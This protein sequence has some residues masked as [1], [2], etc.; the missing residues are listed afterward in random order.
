VIKKRNESYNKTS[1]IQIDNNII[2]FSVINSF[3]SNIKNNI[4]ESENKFNFQSFK[5][6]DYQDFLNNG[7]KI[8]KHF[9]DNFKPKKNKLGLTIGILGNLSVGKTFLLNK[10]FDINLPLIPTTSVNYYFLNDSLRVIDSPGLNNIMG[11]TKQNKKEKLINQKFQDFVIE[12][13]V[14]D[15]SFITIFVI[16]SYNYNERKK[17]EKIKKILNENYK[18]KS[19]IKS[20]LIIHNIFQI[21][22]SKD[23]NEYIKNNF[24]IE[25]FSNKD[26]IIFGEKMDENIEKFEVLHFVLKPYQYKSNIIRTIKSQIMNNINSDLLDFNKMIE[27]TFGE[28]G[29]IVNG[30][31]NTLQSIIKN[32]FKLFDSENSSI[33]NNTLNLSE[34]DIKSLTNHDLKLWWNNFKYIT[35][36]YSCYIDSNNE[37]VIE[38]ELVGYQKCKLSYISLTDFYK[39]HI[40]AEKKKTDKSK[41][42]MIQNTRSNEDI[43]YEFK[44]P[45]DSFSFCDHKPYSINYEK[46]LITFKYKPLLMGSVFIDFKKIQNN[47]ENNDEISQNLD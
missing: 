20:L 38:I 33:N 6:K 36:Y 17:I 13:F 40:F 7:F 39:F 12:K 24:P 29:K 26:D 1:N 41:I 30:D 19:T 16:N 4:I 37:L 27:N 10:I 8:E 3:E 43:D 18:E 46:G 47:D 14:L 9:V 35:P 32:S 11:I 2:Q 25:D 21:K 34:S 22:S 28:I 45:I 5:I 31:K 15:N 42:K 23:Y 44:I